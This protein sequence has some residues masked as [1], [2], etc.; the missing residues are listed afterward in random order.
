MSDSPDSAIDLDT[1]LETLPSAP[2][3]Y[4]MID[5]TG[6]VLYVGKARNLRRRVSS[7][8]H[9]TVTD[10]RL[11]AMVVLVRSVEVTITNTESEA[12]LLEDRLI[13]S[14]KPRYNVLLRDD[15]SYPYIYLSSH[16]EFPRLAFYRGARKGQ[17]RFFGPYPGAGAV[18]ETLS[19]LQKLFPVRQCEDSF[20]RN[21]SR[22]CLQYQIKRCT[23][24]CVGLV[25]PQAYARDVANA[26][27][28]L[29]GKSSVVIQDLVQR[30]EQA[31]AA[32]D[33]EPAAGVGRAHH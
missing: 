15:K 21:R 17:G 23:A 24:P 29:D 32:V 31:C 5:A 2:G 19:L 27:L 18:R 14:I 16:D 6:A 11:R 20:F 1:C 8:F 7:Y 3:V 30:M 28:F 4:R 9:R 22:P 25:E 26:V 13:K 33:L 12:L 10:P